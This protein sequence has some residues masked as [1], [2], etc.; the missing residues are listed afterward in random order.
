MQTPDHVRTQRE[1]KNPQPG[2]EASGDITPVN[3]WV[4]EPQPPELE[5]NTLLLSKTPGLW[6]L[7]LQY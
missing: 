1:V 5:E 6:Y 2:G 3:T 7:L 4:L